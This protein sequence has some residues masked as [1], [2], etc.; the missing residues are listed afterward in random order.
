MVFQSSRSG[1]MALRRL[2]A[3]VITAVSLLSI[4]L[5]AFADND[6]TA[7]NTTE[8]ANKIAYG[9]AFTKHSAEF[10][11]GV[12]ISGL[13]FPDPT[14]AN[15]DAF[16]TF[17]EGILGAPSNFKNLMNHRAAYWD[18]RTGTVVITNLAPV[19]CG[20]AFRPLMGKAYYDAL[21]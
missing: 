21:N 3:V 1:V 8:F 18:A 10:M 19:D 4:S 11:H 15:E 12:S 6:C 7:T 13:A 16:A 9:H 17:L 14:I 2:L 5:P 20:T